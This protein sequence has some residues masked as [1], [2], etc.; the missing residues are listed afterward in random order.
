[1]NT[2]LILLHT[3]DE[4]KT[5][6]IV[7]SGIAGVIPAYYL[8]KQGY[9]VTIIDQERYPAMR[10]SYANGGQVSV[11]NS[12]VWNT[13]SNVGKGLRWM[14]K[15][16]APLYVSPKVEWRKIRWMAKF[17]YH[18]L[19]KDHIPN[20]ASTIQLGVTSRNLYKQIIADENLQ[21]DQSECGILHIYKDQKYFDAA[22]FIAPVYT[23]NGCKWELLDKQ[24][25]EK[26]EPAIKDSNNIIGG[27]WTQDDWVGDIHKFCNELTQV[28][29]NKY[30]VKF[31]QGVKI[32]DLNRLSDLYDKVVVAAGSESAKLAKTIGDNLNIYPVK[33]YSIT[34]PLR[35][36]RSFNAAPKASILDDEEKI[37]CSKLGDRLRVAG[38]AE[39]VGENYDIKRD[40]IDPLLKWVQKNFPQID[41]REYSSWA[42]LR[43]MT[44]NMMPIISKSKKKT[45][46]YYHTGHGHLGWT[47]SPATA[48]QLIG[49]MS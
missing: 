29:T 35:D 22:N 1:M 17:L 12:E 21:F 39:L 14:F 8:A 36:P 45:N 20:T 24:Q 26:I 46:V 40:R 28:L 18:T 48:K 11:S 34:I 3:K 44:P 30:G 27:V 32:D 33:G 25:S 43:P 7:G 6:A 9:S 4:M 16:D 19:I 15:K 42:C 5:V 41:C 31:L 49:I 23:A 2:G 47:L 10:C 37:V 13:W 38:T